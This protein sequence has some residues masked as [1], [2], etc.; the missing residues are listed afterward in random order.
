MLPLTHPSAAA[1][2]YHLEIFF[3]YL[4]EISE[5]KSKYL[6]ATFPGGSKQNCE[7]VT[8]F[9]E[10]NTDFYVK[11]TNMKVLQEIKGTV[12]ADSKGLRLKRAKKNEGSQWGKS[13][14]DDVNCSSIW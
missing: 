2:W 7:S 6:A 12:S 5:S 1:Q 11:S 10:R 14:V 13:K 4:K 9:Q 3:F 8:N